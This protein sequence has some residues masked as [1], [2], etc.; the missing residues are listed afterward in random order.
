MADFGRGIVFVLSVL[1]YEASAR[2]PPQTDGDEQTRPFVGMA[3][4]SRNAMKAE[5]SGKMQRDHPNPKHQANTDRSP[6][7]QKLEHILSYA[8]KLAYAPEMIGPTSELE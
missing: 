5:N 1:R 7:L 8:G 4:R 2:E 6:A 3:R